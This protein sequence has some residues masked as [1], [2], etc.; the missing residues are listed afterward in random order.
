MTGDYQ[1]NLVRHSAAQ[2]RWLAQRAP[3]PA[4]EPD[5]PIVDAHHHLMHL[6]SHGLHYLLDAFAADLASGH[7]IVST[8]CVEGSGLTRA[9]GPEAWRPIG[10]IESLRGMAA[11]AESGHFGPTRVAEAIVGHVDMRLGDGAGPVLDA[12]IE[13][14]GGRLRGIRHVT[15]YDTG[16]VGQH[17]LRPCPPNLLGDDTFRRGAQQL[18]RRGLSLDVWVFHTQLHEVAAL[19]RACPELPIVLNHA[20]T[21]LGVAEHAAT[22]AARAEAQTLW[23]QGLAL[24]TP[25]PQVSIKI[26]GLGMP[27]VGLPFHRDAMPPTSQVLAQAWMPWL[28]TCLAHVGPAR[29]L[30]ESNF[31][32]DRQSC[33]YSELWNAFK[34]MTRALSASER[35][36]L[37]SETAR[38]VYRLQPIT[39]TEQSP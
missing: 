22:P 32:V 38:R 6:P 4:L 35:S 15:P 11:M 28:E 24:L 39:P 31:P 2:D 36:D 5:W 13:A 10:E 9:H 33:G 18:Q 20:G 12:A 8:V 19:A 37:F 7:R 1:G 26:G 14:G 16:T 17:I 27:L 23:R 3:E 34:R 21:L 25:F 29:C 30:F